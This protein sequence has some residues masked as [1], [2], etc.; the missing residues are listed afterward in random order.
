MLHGN[1]MIRKI[2]YFLQQTNKFFTHQKE[3]GG[4]T[5]NKM[6]IKM[7]IQRKKQ[8]EFLYFRKER[9]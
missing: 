1:K 8:T 5:K 9:M 3:K 6:K 2:L 7:K 4:K